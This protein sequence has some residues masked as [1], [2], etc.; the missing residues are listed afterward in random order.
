MT[1]AEFSSQE[2]CQNAANSWKL[3]AGLVYGTVRVTIV[4]MPK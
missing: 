2:T 1:T 4:C 3:Q